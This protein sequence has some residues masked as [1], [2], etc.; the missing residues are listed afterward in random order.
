MNNY[1]DKALEALL[2]GDAS[3]LGS[4]TPAESVA[5]YDVTMEGDRAVI[6]FEYDP[7]KVSAVRSLPGRAWSPGRKL[8]T[9]DPTPD[10]LEFSV[11][12]GLAVADEVLDAVGQYV[13]DNHAA[14]YQAQ[15]MH[16]L[17]RADGSDAEVELAEHLYP[18]QVAGVEYALKAR[19]TFIADQQGLGKTRQAIAAIETDGAYP[20]VIVCKAN[21]KGNWLAELQALAPH[22][23]AVAVSGKTPYEV[24]ADY[25]VVN[26]DIL[27][28]WVDSLTGIKALVVDES[29]LVK[30]PK[31]NR[32]VAAVELSESVGDEGLVMLLTGT[33]LLNRT[34]ELINQLRILGLLEKVAPKPRRSSPTAKDWDYSFMFRYCG[35]ERDDKGYWTFDGSSNEQ[36]LND[37]LRQ[38]GYVRRLRTEVLPEMNPTQRL[39]LVVTLK[40]SELKKYRKAEQDFLDFVLESGG[41]EALQRAEGEAEALV[42][43][44]TLRQL[45]G[46]AKINT[47]VEWVED[48]LEQN[49]GE[50]LLVWAWHKEVQ[51]ALVEHFDCPSLLGGETDPEGQKARYAQPDERVMVLSLQASSEGH[52]LIEGHN[53][54]F[55]EQGWTPG[56]M[57]QA[58]DRANRIGQT[59]EYVFAHYMMAEDT[60][61]LDTWD[62]IEHKRDMVGKV[63]DG[64][65]AV[66]AGS[67]EKDLIGRMAGR[68]VVKEA[69]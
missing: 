54:L 29:H 28:D 46:L 7:E 16:D 34:R 25:V 60:I 56:G 19:R 61:D 26:F 35:P 64:G 44:G 14:M 42:K 62:L 58:E 2:A 47:A 10:L 11:R 63:A 43:L 50:K 53:H 69:A 30:N 13:V 37:R 68:A 67:I 8:N 17:S 15:V 51:N 22:R 24:D 59:A 36:E 33:P 41:I 6:R 38:V 3:L 55:V 27:S 49:P 40:D 31:A 1:V 48:W 20:A 18:F 32:S 39:P 21:L 23:T 57:E 12:Y 52:T 65:S 4:S 66:S 45:A 9:A 5:V